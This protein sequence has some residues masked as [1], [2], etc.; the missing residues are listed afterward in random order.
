MKLYEVLELFSKA[1]QY[2][3]NKDVKRKGFFQ[4]DLDKMGVPKAL[5][6]KLVRKNK[7]IYAHVKLKKKGTIAFY[8]LA[9]DAEKPDN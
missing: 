8:S 1:P 6:K 9:V 5:V 2:E 3:F 4:K 7:I